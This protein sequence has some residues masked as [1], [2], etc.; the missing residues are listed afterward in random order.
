VTCITD[1]NMI[2][3]PRLVVP[4]QHRIRPKLE[5]A[6][7]PKT[8]AP[9]PNQVHLWRLRL[10]LGEADLE[11]MAKTL[12]SDEISKANRFRFE[13]D[14]RRFIAARGQLRTILGRYFAI[15]PYALQ[16]SYGAHGKPWISEPVQARALRFNL[17]HSGEFALI[18]IVLDRDLGVDLEEVQALDDAERI[19]GQFFSRCEN[20]ALREVPAAERLEAFFECWTLKEAFLKATGEGLSRPTQSFDVAFGHRQPARLLR[21]DD[22]SEEASRWSLMGFVPAVGYAGGLAVEG[23]GW[24]VASWECRP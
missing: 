11:R 13:R 17:S 18:A 21:V 19:A 16:F 5:W 20:E 9:C 3:N 1:L 2:H 22:V 7:S 10:M 12:A 14:R 15:S 8:L 6:D 23:F 4:D 24:D